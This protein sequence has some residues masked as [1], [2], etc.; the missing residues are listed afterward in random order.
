MC[1]CVYMC[2][3]TQLDLELTVLFF[4][5]IFLSKFAK[6][7]EKNGLYLDFYFLTPHLLLNCWLVLRPLY[8]RELM[9]KLQTRFLVSGDTMDRAGVPLK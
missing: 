3:C 6:T 4:F 8:I 1:V 9:P 2:V 7:L 5:P